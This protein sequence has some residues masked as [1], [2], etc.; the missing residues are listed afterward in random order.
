[1]RTR[2]PIRCS[3]R[4][5]GALDCPNCYPAN[6]HFAHI[7]DDDDADILREVATEAERRIDA[8]EMDNAYGEGEGK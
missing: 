1:M 4:M 2:K 5:C 6:W 3:D 8:L 7:D